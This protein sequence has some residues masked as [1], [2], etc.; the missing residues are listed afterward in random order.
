MRN[1]NFSPRLGMA[2][3]R[4]EMS[5]RAGY[6]MFYT[7][8]EGLSAGIMSA[9]PPFGSTYTSPG[10]PLVTNPF[11]TAASGQDYGQPFPLPY[12][13]FG[14][15]PSKPDATIDW[16]RYEPLNGIPAFAPDNR[17][18]YSENYML[19]LERKLG[20]STL[21]SASYVGS[22]AH[23]LLALVEANPGNAALCLAL[24][25]PANLASGTAP[26]GPFG[27]SSSYTTASGQ[28]VTG[29]RGPFPSSFASVG[30]Q[31]TMANSNYNALE[32]NLRHS[33]G[34]LELLA[35]YTYSKSIDQS[36]SL[37]EELNPLNYSLTRAPSAFDMTHNFVVSFQYAVPFAQWM[38]RNNR[39][40]SG[41]SVSGVGR[42][43]TGLPVTLFNNNDTS[44][45]GTIPNAINNNGVDTPDYTPGNLD[46]H[47]N[48]RSGRNAFNT[49]L[50]SLPRWARWVQPIGASSMGQGSRILIWRC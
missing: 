5:I 30:Y 31:K 3:S 8:I 39:W 14:S 19:S 47:L 49:A 38:K 45:L 25:N 28:V 35:G 16:S 32:L 22:Q 11:V 33:S 6:G 34:P 18:P 23:H 24:S 46:L 20:A 10:P 2:Y 21:V 37:A 4:G 26:C 43:S 41:W 48:P 17:I 12:V 15:S 40:V 29:T 9:N 13:P 27:E 44:L 36:S 50:F 1:F 7:A 42:F